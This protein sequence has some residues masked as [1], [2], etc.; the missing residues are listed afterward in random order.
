MSVAHLMELMINWIVKLDSNGGIIWD[1]LIG[2]S[3]IDIAYS[4][5]Q[6]GDG[7]YVVAGRSTSSTSGDV[8]GTSNG[9]VDNWIVT[10]DSN[11]N[12]ID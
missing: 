11:G 5:Q 9:F 10:L 12:I 3:A 2:G 4:I 6:T 1:T 7:G 8:S